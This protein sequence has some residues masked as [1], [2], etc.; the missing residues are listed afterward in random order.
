MPAGNKAF[1][2]CTKTRQRNVLTAFLGGNATEPLI[3]AP[4]K[5]LNRFIKNEYKERQNDKQI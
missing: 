5:R 4:I 3:A 1:V 2:S